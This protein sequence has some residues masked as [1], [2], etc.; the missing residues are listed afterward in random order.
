MLIGLIISGIMV[1]TF[2]AGIWE[3]LEDRALD[4]RFIMRG[5]IPVTEGDEEEKVVVISID[6][7]SIEQYG[8]WPW[9][10]DYHARLVNTLTEAGA[11]V[12]VFDI[13][14]SEPDMVKITGD[15]ELALATADSRRVI[16]CSFFEAR[17]VLVAQKG[18]ETRVIYHE[19]ILPLKNS[20]WAVGFTNAYPDADGVLRDCALR[21]K[22]EGKEYYSINVLAAARFLDKDPAEI[23]D[24]IPHEARLLRYGLDFGYSN[25]PSAIVAIYKYND[26]YIFDEICFQKGLHNSQLADIFKNEIKAPVIADSAEPKSIVEIYSERFNIKGAKKGKDSIKSSIDILKRYVINITQRSVNTRKEFGT[27]KWAEDKEGK[28]LNTPVDFNN[29]A[30]DALRYVALNKLM[31]TNQGVYALE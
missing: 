9:S 29:H 27:Y 4:V 26:G 6:E 25:D 22:H 1:V 16:H 8:R 7:A 20:S 24:E 19:P 17:K 15:M 14:L 3:R 10:R 23:I 28:Q 11:K 21:I 18:I 12:I 5:E 13:I 30:I 31:N 2:V